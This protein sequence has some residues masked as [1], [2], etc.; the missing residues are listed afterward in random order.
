MRDAT[1]DDL[2]RRIA[3]RGQQRLDRRSLLRAATSAVPATVL[4]AHLTSAS[5]SPNDSTGR[6]RNRSQPDIDPAIKQKAFDLEYDVEQIFRFV[7]DEVQY[8]P[9]AG[10]LRGSKGAML[11]LAGNSVDKSLLLADLLTEALIP[12][13]FAIGS[14]DD[15]AA[16]HLMD[17]LNVDAATYLARDNATQIARANANQEEASAVATPVPGADAQ[18]AL[19]AFEQAKN[20]QLSIAQSQVSDVVET[21][22]SALAGAGVQLRPRLPRS[23]TSSATNSPGSSTRMAPTGS[24]LIHPFR[25]TRPAN[26]S[27]H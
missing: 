10:A 6:A 21:L 1:F 14:V 24:T 13:R 17:S 19:S 22:S 27:Q 18:R 11:G 7:A 4:G 9:Y 23:P 26:R 3:A 20:M 5:S 25:G 12:F 8:E 15:H 2:V 16:R